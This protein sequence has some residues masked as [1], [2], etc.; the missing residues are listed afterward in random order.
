MY[1]H[2]RGTLVRLSP[3]EAVIEAGGIGFRVEIA[4][5]TYRALEGSVGREAILYVL[6]YFREES[7]RLFG[8]LTEYD[9]R[10]FALLLGVRGIG[11]SHALSLLSG[12][13]IHELREAIAAGKAKVLQRVRGIGRK[14]AERLILELREK[15]PPPVAVGPPEEGDE[16]ETARLALEG[17]GYNRGE[18]V[19]AVEKARVAVPEGGAA[20]WIRYALQ[21]R[22]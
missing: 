11:P 7:Q 2:L 19:S 16:G 20:E 15:L 18:A 10:F 17:L 14:N 12:L 8:F 21:T 4:F 22:A 3:N 13:P 1:D 9:R 5:P 6:P